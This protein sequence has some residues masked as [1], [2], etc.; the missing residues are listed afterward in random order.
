MLEMSKHYGA[1]LTL[2]ITQQ[3]WSLHHAVA[4]T[5]SI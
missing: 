4:G 5:C 1:A 2:V 3:L